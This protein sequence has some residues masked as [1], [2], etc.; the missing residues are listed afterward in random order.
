MYARFA[1]SRIPTARADMREEVQCALDAY[2]MLIVEAIEEA[3]GKDF[4]RPIPD[5]PGTGNHNSSTLR[6]GHCELQ[7]TALRD[8]LGC[9]GPTWF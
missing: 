6:G 8:I 1:K 2:L 9:A 7:L 3:T 4:G 5:R